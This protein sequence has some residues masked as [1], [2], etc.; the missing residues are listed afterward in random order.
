MAALGAWL[1]QPILLYLAITIGY[2]N[3]RKH[4]RPIA[5]PAAIVSR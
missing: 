1:I 5:D 3:W 4:L 2:D